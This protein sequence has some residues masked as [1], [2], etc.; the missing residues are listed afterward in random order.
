MASPEWTA[1]IH[2]AVE[3]FIGIMSAGMVT[4][5][6]HRLLGLCGLSIIFSEPLP[7]GNFGSPGSP[8]PYCLCDHLAHS[9]PSEVRSRPK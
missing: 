9:V 2:N 4:I 7:A 3:M 8:G 6:H 5:S 1:L